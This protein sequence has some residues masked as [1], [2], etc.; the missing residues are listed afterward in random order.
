MKQKVNKFLATLALIGLGVS[1]ANAQD[2]ALLVMKNGRVTTSAVV[3][4][5][6]SIIFRPASLVTDEGIVINGIKW[7]TRNVGAPGTFANSPTDR[8]M[9]YQWNSTTG[10]SSTA[11]LVSTDG[12]SWNN[13]WNGGGATVTTWETKNNV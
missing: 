13:S 1:M 2:E 8:G 12:S 11:P 7:A 6:D 5:V 3:A 4:D 10:W 9:F